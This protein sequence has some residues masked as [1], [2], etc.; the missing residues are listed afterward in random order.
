MSLNLNIPCNETRKEIGI[1]NHIKVLYI[2]VGVSVMVSFKDTPKDDELYPLTDIVA[3][4]DALGEMV[5]NAKRCFFHI[6][7]TSAEDIKIIAS[8]VTSEGGYVDVIQKETL[9]LEQRTKEVIEGLDKI[10]NP[11]NLPTKIQ[12]Q[13]TSTSLVSVLN[14]TLTCDKIRV[15][16]SLHN[17]SNTNDIIGSLGYMEIDGYVVGSIGGWGDSNG[18]SME[19]NYTFEMENINGS[20]LDISHDNDSTARIFSYL[21]EEYTLKA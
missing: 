8:N 4:L 7:G 12:G 21:V 10:I 15:T 20:I 1:F 18:R 3:D 19:Y 5:E 14:K 17:K 6:E 11:Y 13:S 2:P 16:I 9:A